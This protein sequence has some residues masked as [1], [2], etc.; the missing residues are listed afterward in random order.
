[1]IIEE[2]EFRTPIALT[3][4]KENKENQ[5]HIYQFFEKFSHVSYVCYQS[6]NIA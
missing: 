6:V 2:H 4:S 5:K 3:N 1:M